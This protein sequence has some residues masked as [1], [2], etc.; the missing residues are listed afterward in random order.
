MDKFI[1]IFTDVTEDDIDINGFA[2]MTS[3]E[4]DAYEEILNDITWE[5]D[6]DGGTTP[7]SFANGEDLLSKIE[8]KL[9]SNSE[10]STL[11]KLF[12]GTFGTFIQYEY[13]KSYVAEE[14]DISD[15]DEED[16]EEDDFDNEF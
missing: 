1:A 8:F 14:N 3:K 11:E 16:E 5:F 12:N 6:Y 7:I 2:L 9:I 13:I 4:I 10:Y 15:D